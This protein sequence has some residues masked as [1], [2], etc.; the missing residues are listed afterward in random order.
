MPDFFEKLWRHEQERAIVLPDTGERTASAV[1]AMFTQN[2]RADR[3]AE[4]QAR[5]QIMASESPLAV[6]NLN[7]R[8]DSAGFTTYG[9]IVRNDVSVGVDA[10]YLD[11]SNYHPVMDAVAAQQ[12]SADADTA[13]WFDPWGA[14]LPNSGIYG[15]PT[16]SEPFWSNSRQLQLEPQ[17]AVE[18]V[19]EPSRSV[20]K[21]EPVDVENLNLDDPRQRLATDAEALLGYTPLREELRTPGTLKRALAKLEM[22]ILDWDSVT[23]YKKQMAAHYETAGKMRQ[24][25]WRLTNLKEYKKP[26]PEYVLQKAVEIKKVLPEAEFYVEQLAVDPFLIVTLAPLVDFASVDWTVNRAMDPEM[27]AYVEVWSEPKFEATM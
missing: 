11:P 4:M 17:T 16:M 12:Q 19:E 9:G 23:A 2:E 7:S 22:E 25:T 3:V 10:Y 20:L 14:Y 27:S 21:R 15:P 18:V 8:I 6:N 1:E 5:M 13:R 26:V 24:P